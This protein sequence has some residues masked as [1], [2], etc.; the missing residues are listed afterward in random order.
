MNGSFFS[1][2]K[3]PGI[4]PIE[5]D[6]ERGLKNVSFVDFQ[7]REIISCSPSFIQ[8]QTP[9]V[10][11]VETDMSVRASYNKAI[12]RDRNGRVSKKVE[13]ICKLLLAIA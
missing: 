9:N 3:F 6:R 10:N 2:L 4:R 13:G 11:G 5:F 8:I 1:G 7:R 12:P